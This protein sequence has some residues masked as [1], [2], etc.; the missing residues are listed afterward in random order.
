MTTQQMI[1]AFFDW[2]VQQ[3]G[4]VQIDLGFPERQRRNNPVEYRRLRS[5]ELIALL[6]E[7]S[8]LHEATDEHE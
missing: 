5:D 3:H 7:Y 1:V 8:D 2:I 6:Q 4:P